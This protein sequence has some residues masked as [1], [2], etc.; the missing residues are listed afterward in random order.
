VDLA[1]NIVTNEYAAIKILKAG[2]KSSTFDIDM[3]FKEA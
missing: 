2:K 3:I 1:Q